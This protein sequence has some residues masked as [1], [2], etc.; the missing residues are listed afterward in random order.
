[1][2][3]PIA[4]TWGPDE[5]SRLRSV[6]DAARRELRDRE[7]DEVPVKLRRVAASS[8]RSLPPPLEKSLVDTLVADATFRASVARRWADAGS[9]DALA[10]VFLEDPDAARELARDA[11]AAEARAE[12]DRDAD[13]ERRRVEDLERRLEVAKDRLAEERGRFESDLARQRASDRAARSRLVAS[14]RTAQR[15][16]EAARE[17]ATAA[18][19]ER[20]ELRREVAELRDRVELLQR[21]RRPDEPATNAPR[22]GSPVSVSD[23]S[24]IARH[25]D[26]F[27]RLV[28]PFRDRARVAH[29]VSARIPF[30]LP[31]GIA[32]DTAEAI[33]ALPDVGTELIIV[34]GYNLA[35]SVMGGR[36]FGR[37]G[38]DRVEAIATALRRRSGAGVLVVYDAADVEG[39]TGVETGMGVESVFTSDRSADDEIVDIVAAT[40]ARTV[41]VTNDRDLRERCTAHGAIVVW[42]DAV[43]SW[44]NT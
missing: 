31:A 2:P 13:R 10:E 40:D 19:R 35:G 20:E 37:E 3:D 43:R 30:A 34:D 4:V 8:A 26:R 42:S 32:P 14:A 7:P 29:A 6:I 38:R 25:L 16:L 9:E 23:P 41:V 33:E 36:V 28:R 21:R 17:R 24:A 22:T 39:R 27:E 5:R 15:D 12:H 44:S 1:M 18:E 11:V